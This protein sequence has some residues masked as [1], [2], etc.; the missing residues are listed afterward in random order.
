MAGKLDVPAA[1]P[2]GVRGLSREGR[3]YPVIPVRAVSL[4]PVHMMLQ[5]EALYEKTRQEKSVI[6][7]SSATPAMKL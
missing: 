2:G 6:A 7:L 4:V 3:K 5:P 1:P